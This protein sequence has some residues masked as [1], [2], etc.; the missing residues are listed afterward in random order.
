[1]N[2]FYRVPVPQCPVSQACSVST[3]ERQPTKSQ[4]IVQTLG[5]KGNLVFSQRE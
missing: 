5:K 4:M 3:P 1:M 2:H